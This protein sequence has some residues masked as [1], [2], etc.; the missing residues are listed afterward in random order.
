[1][2]TI[3]TK[4]IFLAFFILLF[5]NYLNAQPKV[6][7]F[8]NASIGYG[9]SAVNDSNDDITAKGIVTHIPFSLGLSLGKK[10]SLDIAFTYYFHPS[11]N[12]FSGAAALGFA[13][14]IN[15]KK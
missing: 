12:Q 3:K 10:H 7:E 9:I 11:V 14:P 2:P 6:G 4:T 13:F 5:S 8:I 15:N 1:M